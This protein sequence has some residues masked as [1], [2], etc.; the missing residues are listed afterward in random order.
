M[1]NGDF[2]ATDAMLPTRDAAVFSLWQNPHSTQLH[3][4]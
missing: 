4:D 3:D 1:C 2:A